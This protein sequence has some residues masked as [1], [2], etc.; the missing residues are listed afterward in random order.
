M[1]DSEWKETRL[2]ACLTQEWKNGESVAICRLKQ[3]P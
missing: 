1:I 3:A 2:G